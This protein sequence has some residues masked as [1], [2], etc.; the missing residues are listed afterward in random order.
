MPGVGKRTRHIQWPELRVVKGETGVVFLFTN[1]ATIF[2]SVQKTQQA[3]SGVTYVKPHKDLLPKLTAVSASS[4]SG[5][6]NQSV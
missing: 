2:R 1:T 4:R 6:L 3:Q 5:I